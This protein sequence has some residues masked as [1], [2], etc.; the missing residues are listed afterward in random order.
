M[1]EDRVIAAALRRAARVFAVWPAD[2][3]PRPGDDASRRPLASLRRRSPT[4]LRVPSSLRRGPSRP[5]RRSC[6]AW[7]DR[8]TSWDPIDGAG[9]LPLVVGTGDCGYCHA[10]LPPCSHEHAAL[11][12]R[13]ADRAR[14]AGRDVLRAVRGDRRRLLTDSARH[15][16]LGVRTGR[17]LACGARTAARPR[18]RGADFDH[19]NSATGRAPDGRPG[20]PT[21][22][23][24]SGIGRDDAARLRSSVAPIM[25]RRDLGAVRTSSREA[26]PE[27]IEPGIG[28][29]P[30]RRERGRGQQTL[31]RL[32]ARGGP[33]E[34][35]MRRAA[36]RARAAQG[37][38]ALTRSRSLR[39]LT[40]R[41][42]A[43]RELSTPPWPRP[44]RQQAL[45]ELSR[46][47]SPMRCHSAAWG[48]A[49]ALAARAR[50]RALS[51]LPAGLPARAE[52]TAYFVVSAVLA[53]APER[54]L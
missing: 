22:T 3:R 41:R 38:P 45:R 42:D 9:L 14:G 40:R 12:S 54:A 18:Q 31:R 4:R 48:G 17:H 1:P 32:E 20:S 49:P 6:R 28:A 53:I 36:A 13:D 8:A 5:S 7:R 50:R 34:G 33:R 19:R 16:V 21:A 30:A 44:C 10:V 37:R 27:V 24:G 52:A 15:A 29:W 47:L 46:G 2:P 43:D 11:P 26:R 35:R 25:G 23:K 39:W 51:E